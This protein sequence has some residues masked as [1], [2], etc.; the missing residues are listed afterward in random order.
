MISAHEKNTVPSEGSRYDWGLLGLALLLVAFG[1]IMVL[2]A[3]GVM[4]ERFNADK[5]FFLKKQL[6]FAVL[7]LIVMGVSAMLPR[8][9]LDKLPYPLLL[10]TV[11]LLLLTLMMGPN[12]NGARRWINLG[13]ISLQPMELA[14]LSLVLYLAYFMATKQAIIKTFDRGVIPPFAV[15][16]VLVLLLLLQPDFG[17]AAVLCMLLFFMCLVGGTRFLYLFFSALIAGGAAYLLVVR[18]PYRF[19]RLTAFLDPF[20]DAQDTGYQLVQSLYA[21]G[22]GK[23]TGLGLGA[24][25]QKLFYLPEAHNDFIMAVVGEELGF[26]G[27]SFFFLVMGLFFWRA[28]IIAFKQESL[29]DR[30]TV[31]GLTLVIGMGAILNLAVVMGVAPPKGVAM[32]FMSYGG[33]NLLCTMACVGFILNYSRVTVSSRRKNG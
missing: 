18:S 6:V 14:K 25:R 4:A 26:M 23:I 2:S 30:L 19:K 9:F 20:K 29:R 5:Y 8:H 21:M 13:I 22:S 15:T 16:G 12:I 27:M 28:F 11:V 3:S 24:G 1:L 32:P 7:G 31:L 10:L 33:S 17:G